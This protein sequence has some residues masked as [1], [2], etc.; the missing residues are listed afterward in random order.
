MGVGRRNS[1]NVVGDN[2]GKVKRVKL[3]VI[4][5]GYTLMLKRVMLGGLRKMV[6]L[7]PVVILLM[8]RVMVLVVGLLCLVLYL[9]ILRLIMMCRLGCAHYIVDGIVRNAHG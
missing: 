6:E 4:L 2:G 5:R 3:V 8:L 9:M 1:G 7:M